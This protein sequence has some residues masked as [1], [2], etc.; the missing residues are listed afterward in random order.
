MVTRVEL[1]DKLKRVNVADVARES[2]VSVKTVYR[3]RHQAHAP[4]L[5]TV[6]KLLDAIKRLEKQGAATQPSEAA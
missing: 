4:T 2:G 6:A 5:D 3:L 1:A